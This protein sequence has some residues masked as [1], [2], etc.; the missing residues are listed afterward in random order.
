MKKTVKKRIC[1]LA[2]VLL[3]IALFSGGCAGEDRRQMV[4]APEEET[5]LEVWICYD[6]NVAGSYY[7]FLWD[8]L[9]EEY[10]YRIDIRNY[11]QREIRDK[12][13]MAMACNELP[14]IFYVPGDSFSELLF[15]AG[16][17]LPLQRYLL[18]TDFRES[19][20]QPSADGNNYVIPCVPRSYGVVY[21]DRTLMEKMNLEI[22]GTLDELTELVTKVNA[23]NSENNT[24]YSAIELGEKDDSMGGLLYCMLA[25]SL[26][27]AGYRAFTENPADFSGP[28]FSEAAEYLNRLIRMHAFPDNFLEIGEPEA[29]QNFVSHKAVMMVHQSSL[30]DHLIQNMGRDRFLT[31]W[32]PSGS[33]SRCLLDMNDSFVPGLAVSTRSEHKKEAA[34]LCVEFAE[35]V[36]RINV[37][38]NG[39][40]NITNENISCEH[41]AVENIQ[42]ILRMT[43]SADQTDPYLYT[44]IL[45]DRQDTWR[46]ITKQFMA[47]TLT[48]EEYMEQS[49][50][51][52]SST[53][54]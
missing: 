19:Y 18:N 2:A 43:E 42:A 29:V 41:E 11:S 6:R 30:A 38:Q 26:D 39:E 25:Q 35:R 21:Y 4:S 13:R 14:D 46:N 27:P 31:G 40:P 49:S 52:F 32:F 33:D 48:A 3:V 28:A 54:K 50:G 8:A 16:A 47:G 1:I 15:E 34:S 44:R 23:Y 22:P 45:P 36:N 9:A 17:C 5:Q 51:L 20:I 10:G 7:V 12:L 24:D 37:E 53:G